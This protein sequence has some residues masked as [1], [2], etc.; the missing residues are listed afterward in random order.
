MVTKKKCP[1]C[2][3]EKYEVMRK[4][5]LR[6]ECGVLYGELPEKK[7]LHNYVKPFIHPDP[8][9]VKD[10]IYFDFTYWEPQL[11]RFGSIIQGAEKLVRIHG[12]MDPKTQMVVK[13]E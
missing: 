3:S 1:V 12:W 13:I 9:K 8:G 4:K 11:D 2:S 10:A 5:E 6:C 7:A